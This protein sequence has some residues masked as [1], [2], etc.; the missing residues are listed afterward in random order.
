MRVVVFDTY[1]IILFFISKMAGDGAE[2][3]VG[4]VR[5]MRALV[6]R[7]KI[8]RLQFFVFVDLKHQKKKLLLL[9]LLLRCAKKVNDGY[10][11]VY[12]VAFIINS[13]I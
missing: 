12:I 5:G 10:N 9:L 11:P 3:T 6:V 13:I 4:T 8:D 7:F 2:N 1:N